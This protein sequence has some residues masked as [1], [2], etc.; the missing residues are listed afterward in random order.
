MKPSRQRRA[1]RSG[2]WPGKLLFETELS[3]FILVGS[4]DVFMTYIILRSSAE[5][6][7]AN[8]MIESNPIARAILHRWGITGMVYF[9]FGMIAVVSIIAEIVGQTRPQLGRN[10]LRLGAVIV[11]TVVVYSLMLMKQNVR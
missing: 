8:V 11:A 3:W 9:K 7:T 5:G 1:K 4:L 2:R 10:L 6:R